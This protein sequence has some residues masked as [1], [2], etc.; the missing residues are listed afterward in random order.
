MLFISMAVIGGGL[1][2]KFFYD[3]PDSQT[4]INFFVSWF[5]IILGVGGVLVDIFWEKS[6][7]HENRDK[8]EL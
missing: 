4:Q 5:F 8:D 3:V 6:V 7:D 1:Y 2:L